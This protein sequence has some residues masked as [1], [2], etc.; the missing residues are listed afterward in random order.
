MVASDLAELMLHGSYSLQPRY[1]PFRGYAIAA[2][3]VPVKHDVVTCTVV[4]CA[5]LGDYV[6][7]IVLTECRCRVV[8]GAY[9][10]TRSSLPNERSVVSVTTGTE[11]REGMPALQICLA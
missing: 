10:T 11:L 9:L 5:L 1:V 7:M 8:V 4:R 6:I 3:H 2:S